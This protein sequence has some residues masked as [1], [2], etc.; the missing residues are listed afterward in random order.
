[1]RLTL[2]SALAT[3]CLALPVA[4]QECVGRN[5][6]EDMPS[7]RLSQLHAATQ[8]VPF[9]QGLFWR[10]TKGDQVVT[11]LGTYHFD[12]PRHAATMAQFGPLIDK[13]AALLVEAGPE[14]E[15]R[16]GKAMAENPALIV[17]AT[18]PTLPERLGKEEWDTL[19]KAMELRGLPAVVTSRMRPWYVS[20]MLGISPCMM[21][22][23]KGN[24]DTG[25]LDHQLIERAEAADVPVKA[26]EPWDTVFTLFQGMTPQEE[27]DMIRASMPA[28]EYADDY[29]VTLTDAYFSGD[30][31]LIWEFGRF[32]AYDNSGMTRA[33]VDYQM[34][35]AQEKLM[36][37]RN[38][39][40]IAPIEQAAS[41]AGAQ[42][43]VAGFGALHL[44][45]EKGVLSLL[46]NRG[47]TITPIEPEGANGG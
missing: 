33:E 14:E 15:D 34:D 30:S 40:W 27:I 41:R 1:M 28:A 39:A 26:L 31:W 42:G 18:G 6:F 37:E 19:W 44:P 45:G 9:H 17:D 23:V 25:G 12:D 7:E 13:A 4:A 20:M 5:L 11:L 24:G 32:D 36:D 3:L 46:Q 16:L 8:D 43:V 47:W 38:Q 29:T 21:A 10:A 22:Q 2:A 35:R